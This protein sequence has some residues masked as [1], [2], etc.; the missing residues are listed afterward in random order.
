MDFINADLPDMGR[1]YTG[2]LSFQRPFLYFLDQLPSQMI[3]YRDGTNVHLMTFLD[4]FPFQIPGNS[5]VAGREKMQ[6]FKV[7]TGRSDNTID[8]F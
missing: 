7:V 8:G 5:S 4:D 3:F 2:I 6:M 1:R